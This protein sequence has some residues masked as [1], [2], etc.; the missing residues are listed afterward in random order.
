MKKI[1]SILMVSVIIVSSVFSAGFKKYEGKPW[2]N[3]NISGNIPD[4]KPSPGENFELNTNYDMYVE[5]AK[6]GITH[7]SFYERSSQ[8]QQ[9]T[10]QRILADKSL[11]SDELELL[12]GYIDLF[13][14]FEK[15]NNEG[16]EPLMFYVN[17]VR[18]CNNVNDLSALVREGYLFG[19]TFASFRI[20]KGVESPRE[21]AVEITPSLNFYSERVLNDLTGEES[22]EETKEIIGSIYSYY[23]N[24]LLETG[25]TEEL[26]E[27]MT[28][29]VY[30]FS[31]AAATHAR[32]N[33]F[34]DMQ[35]MTLDEIKKFST[36][37]Y[38]Q[39]IG[40]GY[41]SDDF[42]VEYDIYDPGIF[43]GIDNL[44]IDDNLEILK[45]IMTLD[46][47]NYAM[48]Y[49][50]INRYGFVN[51]LEEGTEIDLFDIA[52]DFI[53]RKLENAVD[54]VFLKFA[55]PEDTRDNIIE[56]TQ[57]YMAAM[58]KRILAST[59]LSEATKKKA[60]EKLDNMVYVVVYP[61]NWIDFSELKELVKDH[62]QNLLDAVLCRDDFY[63]DYMTSYLGKP[64]DRGNWVMSQ[65]R[66]TEANAYYQMYNNS[67]NILAGILIGDLYS[68]NSIEGMLGTIGATI[69]HEITHAFDPN[70]SKYN[71]F[72]DIENWWT[73]ADRAE[74]DKRAAKI[75]EQLNQFEVLNGVYEDGEWVLDEMVADLGGLA[76]S[77]DIARDIKG[78]DYEKFFREATRIWYSV[79][80][81]DEALEGYYTDTHPA[82]YI[83]ANYTVQQFDEFYR[84]FNIK[85][86]DNMYVA[87]GK[88]VAVW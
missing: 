38:D 87:P 16:N 85:P 51:D 35:V 55:F 81:R 26:A 37:L 86:N 54:Q 27:E 42:S 53:D 31:D 15:R 88:R 44:Y 76:L 4:K 30:L 48:S 8:Y 3:S 23:Y 66:T 17:Q 18:D 43:A 83:R 10:I 78:F 69:G 74:F 79:Y 1:L 50:D 40:L 21:Y 57:K 49:L 25:Y 32:E 58:R 12:R 11:N 62:D 22:E 41:Y 6:K 13:S 5:T 20:T 80:E 73:D 64:I 61:D 56:L 60:V 29:A 2:I 9:D 71:A 75:V 14:D 67:I 7:D 39:I 24:L 36:P 82:D 19:N 72:G 52:Y 33:S 77:L 59:W 84:T 65:T 70:G 46:M 34:E 63:R 45:T 47:T 28:Q 68:N